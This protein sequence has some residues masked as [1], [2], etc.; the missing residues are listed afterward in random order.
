MA[1][2]AL[3]SAVPATAGVTNSERVLRCVEAEES[4]AADAFR[5]FDAVYA[6]RALA[7]IAREEAQHA[8]ILR[9]MLGRSDDS[10]REY[11]DYPGLQQDYL[12]WLAEGYVDLHSA[13]K[14]GIEIEKRHLAVLAA[15]I[16]LPQSG[17]TSRRLERIRREDA[18]H[19]TAFIRLL[20]A[21]PPAQPCATASC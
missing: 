2:L 18:R 14:V 19:L 3:L 11:V 7:R 13:A 10:P 17:D 6:S 8:R 12:T 9:G 21:T 15:A 16:A 5:A 20:Q 1:G 4:A